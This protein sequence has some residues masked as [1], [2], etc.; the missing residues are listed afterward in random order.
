MKKK[1]QFLTEKNIILKTNFIDS[2]N[3]ENSLVRF[4]NKSYFALFYFEKK[5]K[6]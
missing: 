1:N 2:L 6:N 3:I 5:K 4:L